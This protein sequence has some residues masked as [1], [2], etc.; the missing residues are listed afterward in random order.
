[1]PNAAQRIVLFDSGSIMMIIDWLA[2]NGE[3]NPIEYGWNQLWQR[4]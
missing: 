1:M 3:M 4:F 2:C